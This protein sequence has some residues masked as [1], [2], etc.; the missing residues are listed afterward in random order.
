MG[1]DVQDRSRV[2][3]LIHHSL[4]QRYD[5]AG[6]GDHARFGKGQRPSTTAHRAGDDSS[7]SPTYATNFL[8]QC[9]DFQCWQYYPFAS[10]LAN[11][12]RSTQHRK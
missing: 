2:R 8:Q 6:Y 10:S 4:F 12:A 7:S 1:Q 11:N 3:S 9:P 5:A